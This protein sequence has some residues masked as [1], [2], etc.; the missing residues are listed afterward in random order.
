ML[1]IASSQPVHWPIAPAPAVAQVAAV[2]AVTPAQRTQGDGQ[3]GL[4]SNRDSRSGTGA[5]SR[6]AKNGEPSSLQAAPLLPR[7]TDDGGRP[8]ASVKEA[9]SAK[10]TA[11]E[12]DAREEKAAEKALNWVEVLSTVWKASAAVV[13]DALGLENGKLKGAEAGQSTEAKRTPGQA[14]AQRAQSDESAAPAPAEENPLLGRAAGDPV[15]Y[16]EQGASEWLPLEPGRLVK[17]KA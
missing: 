3:S 8:A 5:D 11:K 4:G 13:E 15:A 1:N 10:E 16:T 7:E 14:V 12:A 2:A 6:Q 17:E 9:E